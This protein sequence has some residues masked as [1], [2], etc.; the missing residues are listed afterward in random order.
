MV[1]TGSAQF[2]EALGVLR[3]HESQDR[4][5]ILDRAD[6]PLLLA[7]L[8]AQPWKNFRK[9][10]LAQISGKT[11]VQLPAEHRRVATLLGILLLDKLRR[12][13]DQVQCQEIAFLLVIR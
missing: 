9:K 11:L 10:F 1:R 8:A 13:L 3:I 4:F 12:A 2:R 6:E 5:I 7:H